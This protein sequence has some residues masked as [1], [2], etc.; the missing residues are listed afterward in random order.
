[1]VP[2]AEL[3]VH[4]EGTAP[5]DLVRRIAQR[6]GLDIPEGV[7]AAPD[8]FAWRDFL[9]FL[10]TYDLLLQR[11]PHRRGLPRHRLRVPGLL[12]AGRRD[13]R[14]ADGVGR[15]LADR[16][17]GRR[18]ALGGLAAGIDDAR[19]D[20]GIESRMLSVAVRNYGVERAM[21]IASC[22]APR[23]TPT[24]S[25]SR[26]PATRPATRPS[27][28]SRPTGSRPTP[29]S[30]ARCTPAS[31]RARTPC[32]ARSGCPSRGSPTAC[33]RSRTRSW[34]PSWPARRSCWRYARRATSCSGSSRATRSTRSPSCARPGS[35][36]RSA[37]TIRRTSA[38]AS[39][40]EYAIAHERFG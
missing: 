4:L 37:R 8:R 19:R 1:M 31:G 12:R 32:A 5:P 18:R 9:D 6:N 13:L 17:P 24:S 29:A 26:W 20:H 40:G 10:N 38:P 23:R 22:T 15:P 39:A 16:R 27:P 11:H 33:G 21:E 25:A 30:A 34:S 7:F 14:R 28:T 35:R 36:S 2:K 3:H